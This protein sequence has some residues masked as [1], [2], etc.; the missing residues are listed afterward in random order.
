MARSAY[1]GSRGDAV[2]QIQRDLNAQ[3]ANLVVDGIWGEKTEQWYDKIMNGGNYDPPSDAQILQ[4]AEAEK[5]AKYDQA[6]AEEEASYAKLKEK[7]E[8]SIAA[9]EPETQQKLDLLERNYRDNAEDIENN[10]IKR[11]IGRSSIFSDNLSEN[12]DDYQ[13]ST[14]S[15]IADKQARIAAYNAEIEEAE[16]ELEAER[17][18]LSQKRQQEIEAYVEKLKQQRQKEIL[19]MLKYT[20][21]QKSSGSGGGSKRKPSATTTKKKTPQEDPLYV[22]WLKLSD[23]EKI[24]NFERSKTAY[25]NYNPQVYNLMAAYIKRIS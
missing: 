9:L 1:Y 12:T 8:Q 22:A 10:A 19:Q 2:K 13:R 3:G 4:Q 25:K 20:N 14:Q 5:G 18:A 7:L 24:A 23:K 11:G 15:V 6:I 21:A 16:R 17:A